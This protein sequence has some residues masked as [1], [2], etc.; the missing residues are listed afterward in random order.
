[1]DA[2][3][4]HGVIPGTAT[5]LDEP[6]LL[7]QSLSITPQR[8]EQRYKG[9]N[10]ATQGVTETDPIMDFAFQAIITTVAGLA[11]QH[12]GTQ[13]AELDNFTSTP[14]HGFDLEDGMLVFR[15]PSRTLDTENPDSVS[16]TVTHFPFVDPPPP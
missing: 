11:D 16:F 1:M 2:I 9:P 4:S 10:R 8:N 3:I 14:I 15:D 5:L 7:V 12:P 6:N 13:C